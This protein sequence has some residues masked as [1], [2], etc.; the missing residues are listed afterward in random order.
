MAHSYDLFRQG[1]C[2]HQIGSRSDIN[3]IPPPTHP[4]HNTG[5]PGPWARGRQ[6]PVATLMGKG[7]NPGGWLQCYEGVCSRSIKVCMHCEAPG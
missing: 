2:S 5:L 1:P 4:T 3:Y 7:M 6:G